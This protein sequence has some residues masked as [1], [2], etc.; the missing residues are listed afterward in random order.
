MCGFSPTVCL[1]TTENPMPIKVKQI[2]YHRNGT[3]GEGF[4]VVKFSSGKQ[5]MLATVFE[6]H[7]RIAIF[8]IALLVQ[9]NITP[10]ENSW[11]A[12]DFEQDVRTAIAAYEQAEHDKFTQKKL[13][14]APMIA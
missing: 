13:D 9:G 3:S 2:A 11:R 10:G 6:T 1:S 4:H 14:I 5:N 7:G 8:D 12:E